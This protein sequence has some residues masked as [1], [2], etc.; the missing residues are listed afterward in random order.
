MRRRA[1]RVAADL[2]RSV[3]V[4]LGGMLRVRPEQRATLAELLA[5]LVTSAHDH[6][7]YARGWI[8]RREL[9]RRGRATAA[10]L[11][12]LTVTLAATLGADARR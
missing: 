4:Q 8:G 1:R 3:D 7:L 9:R 12:A 11:A 2:D 6:R 10:Q 5:Q